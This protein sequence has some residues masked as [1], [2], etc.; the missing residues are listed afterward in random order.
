MVTEL[1]PSDTDAAKT[2]YRKKTHKKNQGKNNHYHICVSDIIS[3]SY[4]E[5]LKVKKNI[6]L[7][8]VARHKWYLEN[9]YIQLW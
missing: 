5:V 8:Y 2:F 7:S 3:D 1:L 4:F 6:G 9:Q